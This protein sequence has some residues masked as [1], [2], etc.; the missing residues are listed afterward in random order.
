MFFHYQQFDMLLN[1][2]PEFNKDGSYKFGNYE[3]FIETKE[4]M[5]LIIQYFEENNESALELLNIKSQ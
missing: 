5:E 2:L 1:K 3:F 4:I